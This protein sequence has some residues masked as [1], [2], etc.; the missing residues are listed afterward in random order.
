[1][2]E[3]DQELV[4]RNKEKL[5][6]KPSLE[7]IARYTSFYETALH[8]L[9]NR[10]ATESSISFAD[11]VVFDGIESIVQPQLSPDDIKKIISVMPESLIRLSRAA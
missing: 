11:Q 8:D 9:L 2:T 4:E 1:M 7:F 5:N 6:L 3:P 10:P